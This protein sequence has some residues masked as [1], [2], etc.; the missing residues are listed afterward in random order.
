M[1][2]R[3][4]KLTQL[5]E[6]DPADADLMYMIALEHAKAEDWPTTI[7]WLDRTLATDPA[8]HYAYFQKA[9]ALDMDGES[10]EAVAVLDQG[11]ARAEQANHHKAVGELQELKAQI[12][13]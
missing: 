9:K 5:H 1:S 8:Y 12:A 13:G 4:E 2:E 11:I 6:A 7:N 10:D 3:L